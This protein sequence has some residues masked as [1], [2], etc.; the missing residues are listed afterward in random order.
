MMDI[1]VVFVF[2][3]L[4]CN[5]RE[6][7]PFATTTTGT[8]PPQT[9]TSSQPRRGEKLCL[10]SDYVS[11][12]TN[13]TAGIQAAVDSCSSSEDGGTVIFDVPNTNYSTGSIQ[14]SGSNI[15]I[16]VSGTVSLLAGI[17]R[18]DYPGPQ[19][20]WYLLNFK[21][22]HGC[23][24]R[25]NGIIDGQ[26][27]RYI[28]GYLFDRAILRDFKD[29][30]CF[31]PWECRPRMLGIV[32]STEIV[33]SGSIKIVDPIY[34][35]VHIIGSK[36]VSVKD[37]T[38]LGDWQVFNNDGIDVDSSEDVDIVG[39]HIDTADDA[40]CIKTTLRDT[41]TS[42]V[43][44]R[45]CTLRSRAAAIKIGSESVSD[46]NDMIFENIE[47]YNTHRGLG[48]QLRDQGDV[49][50]IVFK[51]ISASL[52]HEEYSW[53]GASE[54]VYVTAEPRFKGRKVGFVRNV[55][56]EDIKVKSENGIF[57]DGGNLP[58]P[59]SSVK[60]LLLQE[61]TKETAIEPHVVGIKIT[62]LD[63]IL[64]LLWIEGAENILLRDVVVKYAGG[65]KR[66]EWTEVVHIEDSVDGVE[67]KG[68]YFG[69][70]LIEKLRPKKFEIKK[71]GKSGV[72]EF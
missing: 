13:A 34:W 9:W 21:D 49:S 54:V 50:N 63:L 62:H 72:E 35:T 23:S 8:P 29:P 12:P 16:H 5:A 31:N 20:Y 6:S 51:N 66:E 30:S 64:L 67:M 25:G 1:F 33:V 40:V 36:K 14:I 26:A 45:D 61:T 70:M 2:L 47:I 32:N 60:N 42:R 52:Q 11:D 55:T 65:P 53:W 48:I 71:E 43:R 38:I 15:H 58:S 68:C 27:R 41:P 37:L 17:Y 44:V 10:I 28:T 56:F 39:C 59:S 18:E 3:A 57:I 4:G 7:I 24:L 69:G 22:C 19:P 46:L